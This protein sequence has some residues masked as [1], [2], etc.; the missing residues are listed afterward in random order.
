MLI[1]NSFLDVDDCKSH[2]CENNAV[3]KD[4]TND[5]ECLCAPGWKGKY[6]ETGMC[7][8]ES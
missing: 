4:K 6:C 3:C 8:T 1:V 2:V 5:Y 7:L